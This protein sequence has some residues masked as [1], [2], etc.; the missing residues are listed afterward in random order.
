LIAGF[1]AEFCVDPVAG[2]LLWPESYPGH[3]TADSA[4][5]GFVGAQAD[6]LLEVHD[7]DTQQII[8]STDKVLMWSLANYYGGLGSP[9][10]GSCTCSQGQR[11]FVVETSF[12]LPG[13]IRILTPWVTLNV[14]AFRAAMANGN[15]DPNAG[16]AA[17]TCGDS[18]LVPPYLNLGGAM[19]LCDIVAYTFDPSTSV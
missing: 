13:G 10:Y 14:I 17:I 7:P 5:Y 8:A 1:R 2:S 16:S 18:F 12:L 6:L 11:A 3:G 9:P 4:A 19:Y 15:S